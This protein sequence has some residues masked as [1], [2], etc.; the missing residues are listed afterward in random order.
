MIPPSWCSISRHMMAT[1]TEGIV[2]GTSRRPLNRP[3]ALIFELSRRA[4]IMPRI[5]WTVTVRNTC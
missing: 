2:Q 5:V 1:T 4:I 3:R